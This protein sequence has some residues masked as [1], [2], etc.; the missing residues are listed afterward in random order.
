MIKAGKMWVN[1]GDDFFI[2]AFTRTGNR[3]E[4][5]HISKA[6]NEVKQFGTFIDV[7][8]HY[9]SWTIHM[10]PRFKRV[11]AFE[12]MQSNYEVLLANTE[13]FNNVEKIN[14]A[15]GE[16]EGKVEVGLGKV[17]PKVVGSNTGIFTVIG[18][19]E[20]PMVTID[21][22]ELDDVGLI[23]VDVEGYELRVFEGAAETIKRCKPFIVFEE[24]IRGKLEHDI[25][26]GACGEFLESLGATYITK[27][28]DNVFYKFA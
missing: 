27:M 11:L 4:Y 8:A 21:G 5:Q 25:E 17:Q 22:L 24:N 20:T 2:R 14:K 18:E 16:R 13:Q 1:E 19:G 28:G 26:L 7:G 23:K 6:M 3:Y 15:V 9:G 12:P 10:A